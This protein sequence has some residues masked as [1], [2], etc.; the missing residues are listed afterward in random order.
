[1]DQLE[2]QNVE[3]SLL[4]VKKWLNTNFYFSKKYNI[5]VSIKDQVFQVN[6]I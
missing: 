3:K 1:M 2:R 5:T 6:R 4:E